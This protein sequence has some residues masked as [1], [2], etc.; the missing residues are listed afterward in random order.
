MKDVSITPNELELLRKV[1]AMTRC[2]LPCNR[3]KNTPDT[4][5]RCLR[6][7]GKNSL[8]TTHANCRLKYLAY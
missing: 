6:A 2:N 5:S 4:S 1:E 3:D 8:A 7:D